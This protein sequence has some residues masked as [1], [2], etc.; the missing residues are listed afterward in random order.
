MFDYFRLAVRNISHRKKRSWLTIIGTMVG[1]LAIVSLLSIGQG[2]ENSVQGELQEL[3]GNK[4]FISPGG[5]SLSS[6]F[7]SSTAKL[8]D[9][10]LRTIENTRGVDEAVGLVSSSIIASYGDESSYF[11]VT[12]LPTGTSAGLAKEASG[13]EV[14]EGRYLRD[15]DRYSILVSQSATENRFEDELHLR[16][17]LS[18]N[19]TDYR[20]VG[21]VETSGTASSGI[22]MQM[23]T[24]RKVLDKE[25]TYDQIIARV[26]PGYQP[27]EVE[28]NIRA[29][30]RQNRG[31]RK[32]EEDFT[33]RTAADIISSFQSQL[34]LIRGFLVGLG[35]ISLL[36][37]GVG[38]MNTMYTSVTERTQEVGV[39]KAVGATN[40]Q[41][42]RIFLI[43]SGIIGLV[44]GFFGVVAGLGISFAASEI[45]S[46]QVGLEMT[47]GASP[48]MILG[49]MAF[50]FVIGTL[51][52]FL[53]ARK[54]A[55]M[56]PVDAL[57]YDK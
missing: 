3:G 26:D 32:G 56:N 15:N 36:V 9:E 33:T 47:P 23:E 18:I 12:G 8:T 43:E 52:G 21:I 41:I 53:P 13:L 14:V 42:L 40:W 35:A 19:G 49:A 51:S 55:K 48:Q 11:S 16:S 29:S 31:L 45:I 34:A 38:I 57:R 5:N 50:A 37:G 25:D 22:I 6:R 28:E 44:G 2:L 10:S 7:T 4:V 24:A 1:I 20:V 17:K 54:A 46:Q 27:A 30:L 39:M